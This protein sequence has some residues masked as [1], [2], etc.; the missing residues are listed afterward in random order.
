MR[1]DQ[2]S[3]WPLAEIAFQPFDRLDIQVVGRFVQHKQFGVGE[4][5]TR[6]DGAGALPT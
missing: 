5:Q 6:Q 4:Q 3:P 2:R 1:D